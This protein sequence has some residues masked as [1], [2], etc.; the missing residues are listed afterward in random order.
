MRSF[1]ETERDR[2]LSDVNFQSVI[3]NETANLIA[4]LA[5]GASKTTPSAPVVL[6]PQA[7]EAPDKAAVLDKARAAIAKGANREQVIKRL[8][9]NGIDPSTLDDIEWRNSGGI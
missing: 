6:K 9:A 5:D 7:K 8:K 3:D 2:L 1:P 4:D